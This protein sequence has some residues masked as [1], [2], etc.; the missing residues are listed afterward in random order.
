M[1]GCASQP[2]AASTLNEAQEIS[3]VLI[4]DHD[5]HR[6][7]RVTGLSPA[8]LRALRAASDHHDTAPFAVHTAEAGQVADGAPAVAGEL[9][10]SADAVSFRPQ[11][12]LS[13]GLPYRVRVRVPG[14]R[15]REQLVALPAIA[16]TPATVV[17]AISPT[18]DAV[19]ENLL[20]F[21]IR[22]SQPMG[23]GD[24]FA[25]IRLI[26]AATGRAL[27]HPWPQAE[28]ELWDRTHRE[29]TLLLDP[30]RIKRGLERTGEP[31]GSLVAG[32]RYRLEID[33]G[34][35]DAAGHSLAAPFAKLFHVVA[36]DRIAPDPER[37]TLAVP[38]AGTR[39]PLVVELHEP[40]DGG[41]ART[42]IAIVDATGARL[43]GTARMGAAERSW[44]FEPAEPWPTSALS[45]EIWERV[46][47]LAGNDLRGLF[48]CDHGE[49]APLA[50]RRRTFACQPPDRSR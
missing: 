14:G 27:A 9:V 32:R 24:A 7:M 43:A 48:D 2:H 29:L 45:L 44:L 12:P 39:T 49:R 16:D 10:W 23:Q 15:A 20:R 17:E 33:A 37:W 50:A 34:W 19:P 36:P 38:A 35:R 5:G 8:E 31:T 3:I 28:L 41:L 1:I 21:R 42:G 6:A 25:H 18:G 46:S 11:F 30:G 26:D 4:R 13:P 40:L 22:F 47:D